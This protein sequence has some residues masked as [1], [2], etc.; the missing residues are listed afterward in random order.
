[1]YL[2]YLFI[3]ILL[4]VGCKKEGEV[5]AIY[6]SAAEST[7]TT[8]LTADSSGANLSILAKTAKIV[9]Q[10]INAEFFVDTSLISAYNASTGK[11]YIAPPSDSYE[12]LGS[13]VTIKKANNISDA[14]SLHI[15]STKSYKDG[16]AYVI[17][18]VIRNSSV[19][20]ILQSSSVLYVVVNKIIISTVASLSNNYFTVDMS[21]NN[22]DISNMTSITYEARVLVNSFQSS[23]PFISTI[24]GIEENFLLRF[25]DVTVQP[26]Q[27]QMAGGR[28]ATNVNMSFSTN[29]WY[30]IAATYNGSTLKIYV[31]GNLVATKDASR[32]INLTPSGGPFYFGMSAN[33]RYL[34][35]EISE[36]RIWSRTLSQAEIINGMCGVNPTSTGLQGYWKFNEGTGNVAH[37]ISGHGHDAMAKTT[38]NWIPDVRCN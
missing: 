22:A 13:A 15:K 34:D 29:I 9:N 33:G 20:P 14:I 19:L 11:T 23:S 2:K 18:V 32:T 8:S 24:M 30:H 35:G 28:T 27:L 16:Y 26:N 37:D 3:V 6:I 7:N 5:N 21:K 31:N 36:A 12:L 1:M 38:V 4:S 25:G 17:P 10:D